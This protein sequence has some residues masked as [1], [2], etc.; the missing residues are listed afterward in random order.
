MKKFILS[1]GAVALMMTIASC[2]N[3]SA[4]EH[5]NDSVELTEVVLSENDSV[6]VD[7]VVCDTVPYDTVAE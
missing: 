2:S 6:N 4:E 7:T 3:K 1:M 5:E